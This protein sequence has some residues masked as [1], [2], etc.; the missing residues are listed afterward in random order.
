MGTLWF[1]HPELQP[2][3]VHLGLET[4][5]HRAGLEGKVVFLLCHSTPSPFSALLLLS[6]C[7]LYSGLRLHQ[8]K[9]LC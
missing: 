6:Q 1:G 7:R 2:P 3:Q 8:E 5:T 9:G 4:V